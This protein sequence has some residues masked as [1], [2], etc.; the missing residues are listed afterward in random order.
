MVPGL[1]ST[2]FG[3]IN[4]AAGDAC[5]ITAHVIRRKRNDKNFDIMILA[6]LTY[7]PKGRKRFRVCG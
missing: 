5:V 3:A 6:F 4:R 7:I 1:L 2:P